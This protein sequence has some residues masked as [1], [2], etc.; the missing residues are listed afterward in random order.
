VFPVVSYLHSENSTESGRD[1]CQSQYQNR[2]VF[3]ALCNHYP[4]YPG[5]P[6]TRQ[7][8]QRELGKRILHKGANACCVFLIVNPSIGND[9]SER[10]CTSYRTDNS[11]VH[12]QSSLRGNVPFPTCAHKRKRF[13][14]CSVSMDDRPDA[15]RYFSAL[16]YRVSRWSS[17]IY[18]VSSVAVG[19][20]HMGIVFFQRQVQT[21]QVV[22][23]IF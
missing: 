11:P 5:Y 19:L 6:A 1:Q 7:Q 8:Q 23:V 22:G 3:C 15:H 13:L 10:Q 18:I 17:I 2:F 20:G 9:Q 14:S 16:P 4:D 21:S 12:V